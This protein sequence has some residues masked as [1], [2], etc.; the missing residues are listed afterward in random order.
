[1]TVQSVD[2]CYEI[3]RTCY[4]GGVNFFDNAEG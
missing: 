4:E 3:M 1:M 2:Q